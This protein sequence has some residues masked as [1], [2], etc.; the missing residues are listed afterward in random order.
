MGKKSTASVTAGKKTFDKAIEY[1]ANPTQLGGIELF[2]TLNGP[3]VPNRVAWVNTGAGLHYKV[4]IDRGLDIAEAFYKGMS[5][6]WLSLSG[7]N[8]PEISRNRGL[9]WLWGFYGGLMV[10]CGPSNVGAPGM[11][12]GQELPLHGRHSNLSATLESVVSADPLMNKNEM[13]LTGIVRE[14]KLFEPNIEL[15]RTISSPLG[16]AKIEIDDTF[17]NRGTVKTEHAW[18]LHMNYGYPLVE[19]GTELIYRGEIYPLPSAVDY[20]SKRKFQIAPKPMHE[21]DVNEAVAYIDPKADRDGIVHCGLIN[22]KRGIGLKISFLKKDFPRIANWH[23]FGTSGQYVMGIEPA[24]CGVEGR[25]KDR[26]RGWLKFLNPGEK[27]HYHCTV[28]VL[29]GKEALANFR[30]QAR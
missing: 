5:L 30:K 1:V 2:S 25:A 9:D 7:S 23:H 3:G 22:D 19:E 11:D 14:A 15:R 16:C 27:K 20:F 18:L 26:E 12:N 28:E 21:H 17:I 8:R 29:E 13:S 10:S 6:A 4:V 24:N